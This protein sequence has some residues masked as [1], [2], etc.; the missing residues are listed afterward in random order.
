MARTAWNKGLTKES[1]PQLSQTGRKKGSVPWNKGIKTGIVPKTAFK[2][3]NII[4]EEQKEI[5]SNSLS[6]KWDNGSFTGM[7]GKKHTEETKFKMSISKKEEKAYQWK[8]D[9]V[10][11]SGLHVWLNKKYGKACVCENESCEGVSNNYQWAN[12]TNQY[13]REISDWLQLCVSCHKKFDTFKYPIIVKGKE[14]V[15][16]A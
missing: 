8:G 14:Y 2:K 4:S 5:L 1:H 11:Y 6:E 7:S 10:G 15:S 16:Y 9:L 3:G 12:K 13:R